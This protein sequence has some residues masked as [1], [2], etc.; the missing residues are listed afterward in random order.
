MS[1][2][3]SFLNRFLVAT[4]YPDF[5]NM[6]LANLWGQAAAWGLIV[7]RAWLIFDKTDSTAWVGVTT[8]A[9]MAP[10]FFVPPLVGVLADRMDRRTL[11]SWTYSLN[12][13][14]NLLLAFLALAGVIEVWHIV[15]LSFTNGVVRAAQMPVSQAFA[16]NL[17][18]RHALLNALSLSAAAM[19][20]SRLIGASLVTPLIAIIG[21]PAA[22]FLCT[23]FYAL[24]WVQIMRIQTRSGGLPFKEGFVENF[25]NGLRYA[26]NHPLIGMVI[27]LVFFHCGLTMAF[28]SLLPGFARQRLDDAD[29]FGTLM[30]GVGAGGLVGSILVGGITSSLT[31]G[32]LLFGLGVLSGGGQILLAISPGLALAFSAALIMGAAQAGFMTVGQAVTQSLAADEFRGRVASINTLSLG[33]VMSLMNLFNGFLGRELSASSILFM[34]GG[35]FIGIMVI[36][37]L[38]VTPRMVYTRGIPSE[39]QPVWSLGPQY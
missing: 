17:V 7:A 37:I 15:A 36:S 2:G 13:A 30:T 24:G 10:L 27:V 18:P 12:F 39:A 33:G 5:R 35:L 3:A 23:L 38:A 29:Y 28:E 14:Q 22:F 21:A 6:W 34:Q 4:Q 20:A 26:S 11:L 9:A 31:R 1:V 16:A 32:R 19:Q 8:F 25:T